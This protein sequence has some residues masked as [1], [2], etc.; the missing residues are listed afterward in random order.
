MWSYR[1]SQNRPLHQERPKVKINKQPVLDNVS[2]NKHTI[3][4]YLLF[5]V[6]KYEY[7]ILICLHS[8]FA[9]ITGK[10]NIAVLKIIVVVYM[11]M[12]QRDRQ[13]QRQTKRQ[14]DRETEKDQQTNKDTECA[15]LHAN[16]MT[17]LRRS[18]ENFQEFVLSFHCG[19][20]SQ[21]QIY[22]LRHLTCPKIESLI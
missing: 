4:N 8:A 3:T 13:I 22:P 2:K 17:H 5:V 21:S 18:K 15:Y 16:F 12:R 19:T 14:R 10:K 7:L 1:T 9:Q 11:C 20:I 6:H